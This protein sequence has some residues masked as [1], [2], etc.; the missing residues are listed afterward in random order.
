MS[1]LA[2]SL[3]VALRPGDAPWAVWAALR[4]MLAAGVVAVAGAAFGDLAA[5]S[6]A[7]LGAACAVAFVAPGVFR[8]QARALAAQGSGAC[9]GIC[10][11]ALTPHSTASLIAAAAVAGVVS[12]VVGTAGPSA[13]GFG[14]MLSIGVAFGQFGGVALPWWQLALWYTV[15]TSAVAVATLSPWLFR[16]GVRE[17]DAAAAVLV[18]AAELCEQIGKPGVRDARDRLAAA[19]ER[20]RGATRH[21]QAE[22]V[23][24]A[25][26]TLYAEGRT[27]PAAAVD[28]IRLA[29]NHVKAGDPLNISVPAGDGAGLADLADALRDQPSRPAA[30]GT[31]RRR[32]RSILRGLLTRDGF[33]NGL[34]LG[35]CLAIATALVVTIREPAHAFWLPLTVAVIVRPEYA[36]VFVRT[37]NRVGGTV[38]G[39]LIATAALVVAPAGLPTAG[40]AAV[41]L[42][43]AVAAAPKLYGL[44]V[45]GVTA[46]ALLSASIARAD[47]VLPAVRLLDTLLGAAVAIVFGYVLWPGARRFPSAARLDAALPAVRAYLRQAL[48]PP[49]ERVRWQTVR[50]DA[51]RLAHQTSAAC[52]HAIA[53]PPPVSSVAREL[54]PSARRLEDVVD[55]ITA[56]ASTVDAGATPTGIPEIEATLT[57]LDEA[58]ARVR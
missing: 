20:A 4:A 38:V 11:G 21:P 58:A 31:P 39:A 1:T 14:M 32:L 9:I 13:P 29:A 28:A 50:D 42:G 33:L 12:G 56:V 53:E 46:S 49:Q 43:F 41:A 15:G 23:A 30:L 19:S 34:R 36:S 5:V 48:R 47:E 45:I 8:F 26:A 52:H 6:V 7:Y 37:V 22:L 2:A 57:T 18:C 44:S 3:R 25:A 27:V 54:L 16:R 17:R 55:A 51:Y 10:A 24:F 40:A 35:S